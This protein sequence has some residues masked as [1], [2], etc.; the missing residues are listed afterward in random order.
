MV[1]KDKTTAKKKTYKK[2]TADNLGDSDLKNV[3]GGAGSG[4]EGIILLC[5]NFG[6]AATTACGTGGAAS[7]KG[8]CESGGAAAGKCSPGSTPG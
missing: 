5:R 8:G 4:S 1:D 2:P 6:G 7:G 3:A